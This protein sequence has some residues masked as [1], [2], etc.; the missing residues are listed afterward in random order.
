LNFA[1]VT[2]GTSLAFDSVV[3]NS[4]QHSTIQLEL[5]STGTSP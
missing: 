3:S 1:P 4:V 2:T 5:L